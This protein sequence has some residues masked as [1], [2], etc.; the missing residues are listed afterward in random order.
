MPV[1][2]F[3]FKEKYQYQNGFDCYFE[4]ALPIPLNLLNYPIT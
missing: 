3:D 4:Y 1:T 2:N